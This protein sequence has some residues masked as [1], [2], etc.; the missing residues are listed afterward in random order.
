MEYPIHFLHIGKC[1]GTTI[2]SL[3]DSINRQEPVHGIIQAHPHRVTLA[4]LPHRRAIFS[5][6][7]IR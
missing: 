6:S 4:D 1:A 7:G 5:R 3:I 2:K